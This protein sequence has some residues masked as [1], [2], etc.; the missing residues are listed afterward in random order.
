MSII[1]HYKRRCDKDVEG[2]GK[3]IDV[4]IVGATVIKGKKHL[5][6]TCA[7]NQLAE[8]WISRGVYNKDGSRIMKYN[9]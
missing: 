4:N 9:G 2:C 1:S 8:L 6:R 5:C 3:R 7:S